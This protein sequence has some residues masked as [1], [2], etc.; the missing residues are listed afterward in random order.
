MQAGDA[1]GTKAVPGGIP[2][3]ASCAV[4]ANSFTAMG[5]G[6]ARHA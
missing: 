3:P 6:P 1:G 5:R 2:P 4:N